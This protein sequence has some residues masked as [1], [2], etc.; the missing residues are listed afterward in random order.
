M[1]NVLPVPEFH[2]KILEQLVDDTRLQAIIAPVGFSKSSI[3]KS[4]AFYNILHG[5]KFQL[6]VSSTRKKIEDHFTTFTKL[7]TDSLVQSTFEFKV[8]SMNTTELILNFGGETRKIQGVTSNGDILGINYQSIRPQV[9]II[10]DLEELEQARSIYRTDQLIDWLNA[11][12]ITRLPSVA[13]G[14]VRLIG[15]NLTK[16]SIVNRLITKEITGW[17][18]TVYKALDEN[19]R[20]IW[21]ERHPTMSLLQLQHNDPKTFA[22]QY[23][24][25]PL[26]SAVS[27]IVEEDLR[28]YTTPQDIKELYM[29]VDT[30]HT[31]NLNS[32]YFCAGIIGK[33]Q[34][35][36]FYLIDFILEQLDVERQA[37][38][39]I[40]LYL[41]YKDRI[42]RLT[43]DEKANQGFGYWVKKLAREEYDLSLP[44]EELKYPSNKEAHFEPHV[45]HFKSN[46][47]YLPSHHPNLKP[48]VDQIVS[49]PSR[50]VNDDAID[51]ISGCL[52]NFTR[53]QRAT[54][55][56]SFFVKHEDTPLRRSRRL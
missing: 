5:E 46:R 43:Y 17:D 34:D 45:P 9:I 20:S 40:K 51:M 31:G 55:R 13:T 7:A 25:D 8:E 23:M 30:T 54:P 49:F 10:D 35:S 6:Y 32:D 33:G 48:L 29:H 24:N 38:A 37:R 47:F 39:V 26:D 11:T 53:K 22:S 42:K 16:N 36:N 1:D 19:N 14:Y 28:F 15:T 18:V 3:L 27:L 21:E 52:D 50:S 41:D 2:D 4:F 12:L 44:I 56:N